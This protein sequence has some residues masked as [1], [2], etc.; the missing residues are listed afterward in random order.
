MIYGKSYNL[1]SIQRIY[2]RYMLHGSADYSQF[3]SSDQFICCT[4]IV[5]MDKL[6]RQFQNRWRLTVLIANL[7]LSHYISNWVLGII[8]SF[9]CKNG[10][11]NGKFWNQHYQIFCKISTI[12]NLYFITHPLATFAMLVLLKQCYICGKMLT[13]ITVLNGKLK[14]DWYSMW[15]NTDCRV[16]PNKNVTMLMTGEINV[17]DSKI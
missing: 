10:A 15:H 9:V 11:V 2:F 12:V 3:W 17:K 1:N 13:C 5:A 6:H 8:Y 14:F 16:H 4:E 7:Y